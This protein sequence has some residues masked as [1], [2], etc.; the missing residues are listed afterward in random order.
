[1]FCLRRVPEFWKMKGEKVGKSEREKKRIHTSIYYR[2][3][4][5]QV[6]IASPFQIL[7]FSLRF[8]V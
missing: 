1:M 6:M 8:P 7:C 4:Q 5:G 3:C 2:H